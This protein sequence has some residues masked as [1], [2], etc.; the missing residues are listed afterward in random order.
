MYTI[1]FCPLIE[2]NG[3]TSCSPTL[4]CK[5]RTQRRDGKAYHGG[6][7]VLELTFYALGSRFRSQHLFLIRFPP[8]L[9]SFHAGIVFL[10]RGSYDPLFTKGGKFRSA[11]N[12]CHP[13][14]IVGG[15][16]REEGA[17]VLS[18][19]SLA[20][21][22]STFCN[23]SNDTSTASSSLLSCSSFSFPCFLK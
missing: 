16:E 14:S 4:T 13:G 18:L 8:F 23:R 15:E 21:F 5:Q 19:L 6:I 12:D 10:L 1:L 3:K 11:L 2:N 20:F 22:C 17:T 7:Y 9:Q